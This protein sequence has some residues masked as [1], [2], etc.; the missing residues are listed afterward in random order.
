[1]ALVIDYCAH[2]LLGWHLSRNGKSKAAESALGHALI[3]PLWLPRSGCFAAKMAC[4]SHSYTALV[5]S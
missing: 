4:T 1:L 2:E 3:R 5:N